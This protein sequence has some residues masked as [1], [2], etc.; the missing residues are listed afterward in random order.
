MA[1][2][3]VSLDGHKYF[4][5]NLETDLRIIRNRYLWSSPLKL[6]IRDRR[7]SH[8]LRVAR[9]SSARGYLTVL[10]SEEELYPSRLV[11]G[12]P[13]LLVFCL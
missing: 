7:D 10:S 3:Q 8:F 2:K 4:N 11:N 5:L 6:I 12:T 13:C 1:Q 9:P